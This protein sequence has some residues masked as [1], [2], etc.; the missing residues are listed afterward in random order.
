MSKFKVGDTVRCMDSSCSFEL[1]KNQVYTVDRVCP[2]YIYLK[3]L[4]PEAGWKPSRFDLD[5][6][7]PQPQSEPQPQPDS[8]VS[9]FTAVH[10]AIAPLSGLD[11]RKVIH[12]VKVLLDIQ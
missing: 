1:V 4:N 2:L 12:A 11:R 10:D 9:A 7:A 8:V 3:E 5:H 6:T